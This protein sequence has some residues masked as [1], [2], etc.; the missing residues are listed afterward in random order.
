[1]PPVEAWKTMLSLMVSLKTSKRGK[2]VKIVVFDISRAHF[3]GKLSRSV[4]AELP[5]EEKANHPGRDVCAKLKRSWYGLQ[6]ACSI[7]Q[8]DYRVD[9]GFAYEQGKSNSAIFYSPSE[10]SRALV[11]GD[12]LGVLGDQDA[13][14]SFEAMLATKYEFKK[15]ANLGFEPKDDKTCSFLNRVIS[16][17]A[18][19]LSS[20]ITYEPDK[21]HAY[22]L[23]KA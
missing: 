18:K 14:D 3:Y 5:G 22:L 9:G 7:W 11:H 8:A 15:L 2:P 6:D 13:I 12:D 20:K 4:Y 19:S 10:D 16:F 23:I 21:R 17:G 1:M